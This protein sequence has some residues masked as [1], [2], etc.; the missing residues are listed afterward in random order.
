MHLRETPPDILLMVQ[1]AAFWPVWKWYVVR[2]TTA[3][4][5]ADEQWGLLAALTVV[6]ILFAHKSQVG[7]LS[8]DRAWVIPV[9]LLLIY[10]AT[11]HFLPPLLRA[12]IA[13]IS[14]CCTPGII[15]REWKFHP[16]VIGLFLLSLPVI[17]TMQ[18]YLG[19]PM[20][21]LV[22]MLTS[23]LLQLSGLRVVCEGASLH[24]NE[25]VISID[26]P[27]SGV[28]MLWAGFYLVLTLACLFRLSRTNTLIAALLTLP[29]LLL[30]NVLRASALFYSEAGVFDFPVAVDPQTLHQAVGAIVFLATAL[31][32]AWI[33]KR[34]QRVD[35]WQ[36]LSMPSLRNSARA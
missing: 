7:Q 13:L 16:A 12:A 26:A 31:L 5:G 27:C 36:T 8:D 19:Y 30:G 22:G 32:I 20:R 11:F 24:W 34:L 4:T 35:V 2:L 29:A 3:G 6:C 15:R 9:M 23:P 17:P 28:R 33:V 18:F 1:M 25:Q 10:A 14:L 21:V